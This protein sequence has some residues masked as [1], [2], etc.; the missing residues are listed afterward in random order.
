MSCSQHL[1]QAAKAA[2]MQGLRA[3][4]PYQL[5]A[6]SMQAGSS[7][8]K[9]L[10]WISEGVIPSWGD[11]GSSFCSSCTEPLEQPA[12]KGCAPPALG[13]ASLSWGGSRTQALWGRKARMVAN[14]KWSFE[15]KETKVQAGVGVGVEILSSGVFVSY[16]SSL[17]RIEVEVCGD[18]GCFA[19]GTNISMHSP[20]WRV[21]PK[22]KGCTTAWLQRINM[23]CQQKKTTCR[24]CLICLSFQMAFGCKPAKT[25]LVSKCPRRQHQA[26]VA[27]HGSWVYTTGKW[28]IICKCDKWVDT[29]PLL[30]KPGF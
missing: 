28:D 5:R 27:S 25:L 20:L 19:D 21:Q 26:Y 8:R 12:L 24:D 1:C 4:A 11:A 16:E 18:P 30:Y 17:D 14:S 6:V 13:A 23:S 2:D 10:F 3:L 7:L 22:F 29:A 9:P 15:L